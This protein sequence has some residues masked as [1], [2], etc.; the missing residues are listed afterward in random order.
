MVKTMTSTTVLKD[1][2]DRQLLNMI[3]TSTQSN[4][5]ETSHSVKLGINGS[6]NL[7]FAYDVQGNPKKVAFYK[8]LGYQFNPCG[9]SGGKI[10]WKVTKVY[11][12]DTD[13][14][15]NKR[16]KKADLSKVSPGDL[17]YVM[18]R[19]GGDEKVHCR[20]PWT[21]ALKQA[22]G[23]KVKSDRDVKAD[24]NAIQIAAEG[25]F[26]YKAVDPTTKKP[27]VSVAR[28]KAMMREQ[29][30]RDAAEAEMNEPSERD[31]DEDEEDA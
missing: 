23:I 16:M 26:K 14:E 11:D 4:P 30:A 19:F 2:Q 29:A 15:F 27:V 10:T 18:D 8:E 28:A 3:T 6:S 25:L 17:R 20:K 12:H 21:K 1:W 7:Q 22:L 31:D 9:K 5:M 13:A 24:L